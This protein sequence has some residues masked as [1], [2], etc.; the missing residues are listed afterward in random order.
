MRMEP[1]PVVWLRSR[2]CDTDYCVEVGRVDGGFAVRD[3]K[4]PD[5]PTLTFTA[6]EWNAFV[7][8][9]RAGDFDLHAL[10]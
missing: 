10:P 2:T 4:D 6:P 7:R 3:S 1:G 5:G 9:V 8:G